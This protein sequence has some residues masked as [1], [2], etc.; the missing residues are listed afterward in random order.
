M[1]LKLTSS[2]VVVNDKGEHMEL[3]NLQTLLPKLDAERLR[4]KMNQDY[5][6]VTKP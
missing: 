5:E 6:V 1:K 3:W 2:E 4:A